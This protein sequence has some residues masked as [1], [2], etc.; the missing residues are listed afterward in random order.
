MDRTFR[1]IDNDG[2]T[3][4]ARPLRFYGDN[5][6]IEI[7]SSSSDFGR[8]RGD[9]ILVKIQWFD[10]SGEEIPPPPEIK[11]ALLP[12]ADFPCLSQN[13]RNNVGYRLDRVYINGTGGRNTGRNRSTAGRFVFGPA[14]DDDTPVFRLF[15]QPSSIL[16][17]AAWDDATNGDSAGAMFVVVR[18]QVVA[19]GAT[20]T[21]SEECTAIASYLAE[22]EEFSTGHEYVDLADFRGFLLGDVNLDG[23]VNLGDIQPFIDLLFSSDSD[24]YQLEADINEDGVLN[25]GDI[26]P[27]IDILFP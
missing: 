27:F 4:Q 7:G 25:L 17:A 10:D 15:E 1:F 5:P 16:P 21:S 3:H 20:W 9:G 19:M 22:I 6:E 26:R 8:L 12:P 23:N 11:P 2:N 14:V 13:F 18:G 24:A